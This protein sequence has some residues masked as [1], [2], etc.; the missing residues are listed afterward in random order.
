MALWFFIASYTLVNVYIYF[1]FSFSLRPFL[2]KA[3]NMFN[4]AHVTINFQYK[5]YIADLCIQGT[6]IWIVGL[7]LWDE[8]LSVLRYMLLNTN[9]HTHTRAPTHKTG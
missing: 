6:V 8:L 1:T 4:N 7:S 2:A 5:I 9:T 3:M